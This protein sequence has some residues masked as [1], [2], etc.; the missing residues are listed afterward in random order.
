MSR[1]DV[2]DLRSDTVTRPTPAMR[3][4]MAEAEVGDSAYGEDPTV[5]RLQA[6]YAEL[7]GKERA[8]FVPSGTMA[9][10]IAMRVLTSPG[11]LVLVGARQHLVAHERGA[12]AMNSG[13][14][15]HLM[16]DS[17]G[18]VSAGDVRDR[19]MAAA[20]H[21]MPPVAVAIENT[22]AAASGA[23]WPLDRLKEVAACGLPVHMDGARLFNAQVASKVSAQ[24][25][26]ASMTT[27]SSCVS[28]GLGA[29]VGSLIAGPTELIERA[30][31]ECMRLGGRMRQA[32]ILAAAGIVALDDHVDRLADDH[33]R[34]RALAE[35]V[36]NRWP[37]AGLRLDD[38]G[39]NIVVFRHDNPRTLLDH[40]GAQGV[41]ANSVAPDTVR[42]VTH[43]D[44]DDEGLERAVSV[45]ADAP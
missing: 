27:V 10:Q 2:V 22:H 5:N 17:D 6:K 41:L 39:T 24:H 18:T 34:A 33:A 13:V 31:L 20:H 43:M 4:A 12:T 29:P 42:F 28:K 19:I 45:L 30:E 26:A 16:E 38:I 8:L 1:P 11:D 32:G 37:E 44:I 15:F 14:Q 35:A 25:M 36:A 21:Q 40:L 3:A 9:N 7:V 23:V